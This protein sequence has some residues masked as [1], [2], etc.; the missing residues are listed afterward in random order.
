MDKNH[1]ETSLRDLQKEIHQI[2]VDHGWW[3]GFER[4]E[5]EAIA[6]MHAELSEALENIREGKKPD[7]HCPQFAGVEVELADTII[8]IMDFAEGMGY[9]VAAAILA[10]IEVNRTRPYRHGNKT[11]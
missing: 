6:L 10:K 3:N 5:G 9:D 8:R 4:N 7:K 2:A 1:V 11:C